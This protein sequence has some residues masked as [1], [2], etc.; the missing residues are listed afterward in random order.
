MPKNMDKPKP[1]DYREIREKGRNYY[2]RND[3]PTYIN[4]KWRE[5]DLPAPF[6]ANPRPRSYESYALPLGFTTPTGGIFREF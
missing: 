5:W 3:A 4:R 1:V 2:P 6:R